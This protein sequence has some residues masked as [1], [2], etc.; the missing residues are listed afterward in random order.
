[1]ARWHWIILV[2]IVLLLLL[3]LFVQGGGYIRESFD[4][5][6]DAIRANIA[7]CGGNINDMWNQYYGRTLTAHLVGNVSMITNI[8]SVT[9]QLVFDYTIL[10]IAAIVIYG[11]ATYLFG[12]IAGALASLATLFCTH[13]VLGLFSS[14]DVWDIVETCIILPIG[15]LFIVKWLT[16]KNKK[17]LLIGLAAFVVFS[18]VHPLS[19]MLPM[20]MILFIGTLVV[21]KHTEAKKLLLLLAGVIIGNLVLS[22]LFI[23]N[24]LILPLSLLGITSTE[25]PLVTFATTEPVGIITFLYE[26]LSLPTLCLA[27]IAC[28]SIAKAKLE[29]RQWLFLLMLS[30]FTIPLVVAAITG[31]AIDTRRHAMDA[32]TLLAIGIGC[33]AGYGLSIRTKMAFAKTEVLVVMTT[34]A[35]II[36][37]I[38]TAIVWLG[39]QI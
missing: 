32:A 25:S 3:P 19:L 26:Y 22:Y 14:G 31:L 29:E 30:A 34:V 18:I 15:M 1:M 37:I 23:N 27:V 12:W 4:F 8:N 24:A 39:E 5:Q 20:A 9:T 38:P 10:V 17:N 28:L 35:V 11:V 13:S 6:N 7:G 16:D 33:L 36:G 2:G 21:Y